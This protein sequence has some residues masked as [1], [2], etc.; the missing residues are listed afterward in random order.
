MSQENVKVAERAIAAIN[1]RDVDAYLACCTEDVH[2]ETPLA[3]IGATYDGRT[4][5]RRFFEDIA[6]TVPDFRITVDNVEAVGS[7][8]VIGSLRVTGTGRSSGLPTDRP[9]TNVYEFTAGSIAR[10][11]IFF[12]HEEALH[13]AGL[14]D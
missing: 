14:Q 13:A 5:I 11:R 12:D 10:I 6:D 2:L 3:P 7:N 8:R 1:A 9:I 4:A